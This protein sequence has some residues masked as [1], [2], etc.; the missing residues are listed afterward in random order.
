MKTIYF[1]YRI[2]PNSL[3]WGCRLHP[4]MSLFEIYPELQGIINM[5]CELIPTSKYKKWSEIPWLIPALR[6][7]WASTPEDTI[8]GALIAKL[9]VN[10]DALAFYWKDLAYVE[11]MIANDSWFKVVMETKET[12]ASF[13]RTYTTLEEL[14]SN[15]FEVSPE[16][17]SVMPW[18]EWV[19][20]QVVIDIR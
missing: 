15:L 12:L 10:E 4:N 16:N 3:A 5:T 8:S 7:V 11:A 2:M 19:I 6:S 9:E 13:I 18:M 1:S 17:T 14:E 20:P